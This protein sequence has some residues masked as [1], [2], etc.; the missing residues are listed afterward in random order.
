MLDANLKSQL[1]AYLKNIV[2]PVELVA[3]L[4]AGAK[5]QE[6]KALLEESDPLRPTRE[7]EQAHA[8]FLD[9]EARMVAGI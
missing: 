8:R 2:H 9:I 5:S 6:L 1:E 7:A 4:G 3:S